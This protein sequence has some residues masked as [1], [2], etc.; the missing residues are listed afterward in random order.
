MSAAKGVSRREVRCLSR[1]KRSADRAQRARAVM[2][3]KVAATSRSL[4]E[5]ERDLGWGQGKLSGMLRGRTEVSLRHIEALAMVVGSTP[6]EL[7][8]E[9]YEE[10]PEGAPA[11]WGQLIRPLLQLGDKAKRLGRGRLADLLRMVAIFTLAGYEEAVVSW[12]SLF[13]GDA[14]KVAR[15]RVS[16]RPPKLVPE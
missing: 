14:I 2:A 3:A 13:V 4:R 7:L 11:E 10:L 16:E 6:L 8:E 12:L 1:G 9:I 15:K 5:I